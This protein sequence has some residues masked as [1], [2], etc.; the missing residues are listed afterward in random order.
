MSSLFRWHRPR[1]VFEI[2]HALMANEDLTA[3]AGDV[4]Q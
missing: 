4:N 2:E 1:Y 3:T